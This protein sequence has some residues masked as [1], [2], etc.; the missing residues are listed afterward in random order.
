MFSR[1]QFA[2]FMLLATWTSAAPAADRPLNVVL[3]VSDDQ[4]WTDFGFMGHEHIRTPHLDRLASQSLVFRQAHVTSSLCRPSLMTILSGLYPHQH[5]ITSNDP[6]LPAGKKG[7]EVEADP[8][9]LAQRQKMIDNI[10]RVPTLP[11]LLA[12]HGYASFQTGKWWEGDF[13]RGGFTEGMSLGGRHGD[14][15]LEIGRTTMQPLTDFIDRSAAAGKPFFAW[16]APMLPHSPHNPPEQILKK[17]ASIAP[18]AQL[19]SYWANCEWFDETCGQLLDHLDSQGLHDNTLVVF[20]TDNGW[21]QSPNKAGAAA[22]SKLSPYE[23]GLRTPLMFR[24]PGRIAPEMCDDLA[25]S[26]DLAPTVLKVLGLEPTPAMHGIDLLNTQAR[27][28]RHVIFGECFEHNAVDI[29]NPASS[30][31]WRWCIDGHMKL[32][33]PHAPNVVA[34]VELYDLAEDPGETKDLASQQPE[35]VKRLEAELD[36]WW[37]PE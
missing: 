16:Y 17:Y 29:Q 30:L 9:F 36:A 31:R 10:D 7:R 33:V 5:R 28:N 1:W 22:K 3:I 26:I 6:P 35:T 14:K 4:G 27:A 8:T 25:S 24:L 34:P 37:K 13:H 19:A 32:I 18:T 12:E 11:R 21:I 2:P 15:G 23:G 20:I